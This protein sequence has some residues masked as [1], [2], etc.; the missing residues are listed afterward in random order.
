MNITLNNNNETPLIPKEISRISNPKPNGS[1]AG[2]EGLSEQKPML[3]LGQR[4]LIEGTVITSFLD[5]L[6]KTEEDLTVDS[7]TNCISCINNLMK[8]LFDNEITF[9]EI[10][11]ITEAI[12]KL[13]NKIIA[14]Q[15]TQNTT[16]QKYLYLK[17]DLKLITLYFSFIKTLDKLI[18]IKIKSIPASSSICKETAKKLTKAD[19][20]AIS[21]LAS[22]LK[23]LCFKDLSQ[24]SEHIV[25]VEV[26]GSN[27]MDICDNY[28]LLILDM[29]DG[30]N[31]SYFIPN[32]NTTIFK[33]LQQT[34]LTHK[35]LNWVAY[36][37]GCSWGTKINKI[38]KTYKKLKKM[39]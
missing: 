22:G 14:N 6:S 10:N 9:S 7:L 21:L 11:Q 28:L 30:M 17:I 2:S 38:L 37:V 29:K 31:I 32:L 8:V 5:V 27:Y 24:K 25:T 35:H 18:D 36:F 20:Q 4:T 23:N 13:S 16:K 39:R 34:H 19:E 15:L 26:D 12:H 1:R 3:R 33:R